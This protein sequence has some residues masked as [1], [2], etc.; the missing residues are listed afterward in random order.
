MA[1]CC[2]L[3]PQEADSE[4]QIGMCEG[5]PLESTCAQEGKEAGETEGEAEL[6]CRPWLAPRELWSWDSP[7]LLS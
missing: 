6:W 4:V 1:H 2:R 7:P 5:L 3:A